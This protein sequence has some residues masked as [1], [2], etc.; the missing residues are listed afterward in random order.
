MHPSAQVLRAGPLEI[1][2]RE[3][4]ALAEGRVLALVLALY[5]YALF[6]YVTA[7]FASFFIGRDEERRPAATTELQALRSEVAALRGE[8]K[9]LLPPCAERADRP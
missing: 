6:G 1:R 5:G 9:N 4:T 3:R 7:T 8:L 2:S